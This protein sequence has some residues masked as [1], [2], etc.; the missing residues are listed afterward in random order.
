MSP[1]IETYWYDDK[2]Y[3]TK[4]DVKK[5][6]EAAVRAQA[7]ADAFAAYIANGWH[8]SGSNDRVHGTVDYHR[9]QGVER[10]HI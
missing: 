5:E 1:P 2:A 6:I 8:Q 4:P 10:R 3:S 7:P 9:G